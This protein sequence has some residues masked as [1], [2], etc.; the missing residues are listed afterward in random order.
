V[1]LTSSTAD[2]SSGT[3][4][5]RGWCAPRRQR[6]ADLGPGWQGRG[7]DARTEAADRDGDG[8][9]RVVRS[10]VG[11]VGRGDTAGEGGSR[12]HRR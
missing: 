2:G 11:I 6:S 4:R 8:D 10:L 12:G 1:S 3:L 5:R 7:V 9:W